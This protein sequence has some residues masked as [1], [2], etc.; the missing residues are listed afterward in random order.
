MKLNFKLNS[1]TKIYYLVLTGQ[2]GSNLKP[3]TM[4]IVQPFCWLAW[5][6]ESAKKRIACRF[7]ILSIYIVSKKTFKTFNLSA[8][9]CNNA[10][11]NVLELTVKLTCLRGCLDGFALPGRNRR[12]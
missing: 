11:S 3:T 1:T 5:H 6:F 4:F 7:V 9:M 2:D 10:N 12:F 8:R